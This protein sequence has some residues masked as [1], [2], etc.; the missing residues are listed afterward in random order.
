MDTV[1]FVGDLAVRE[2]DKSTAT[3]KTLFYRAGKRMFDIAAALAGLVVLAPVFLIIAIAI[4][5]EDGGA[6][7]YSQNRNGIYGK[8][9]LMYKFRTMC[10]NAE[11]IHKELLQYNELDGPAFKMKEDP[12]V[13]KVGKFLRRTSLDELPQLVNILKGE[14]SFVGPRPLPVYETEQCNAYQKQRMLIKPGLTCYWQCNG[15]NNIP[16]DEWIEMDLKYIREAGVLTD[17]KIIWKTFG[18]VI[19][20]DGAC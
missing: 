13:T 7:F 15:R 19:N 5:L 10:E 12:R 3:G 1:K 16:F 6:V 8:V 17:I 11:E 20:G 4:K 9:F 2:N 14:M 18:A